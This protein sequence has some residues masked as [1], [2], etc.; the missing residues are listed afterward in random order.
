MLGGLHCLS[1]RNRI[2]AQASLGL[3]ASSNSW[4]VPQKVIK[5][6]LDTKEVRSGARI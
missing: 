1:R 6:Q 4:I 5:P 3:R 2:F